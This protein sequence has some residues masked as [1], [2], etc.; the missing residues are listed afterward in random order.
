MNNAKVLK[1]LTFPIFL[2]GLARLLGGVFGAN[3][4]IRDPR[5]VGDGVGGWGSSPEGGL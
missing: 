1:V 4:E 2:V 3:R 5:G